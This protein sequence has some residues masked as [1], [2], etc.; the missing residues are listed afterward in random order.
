MD[1]AHL[2]AAPDFVLLARRNN[3][4]SRASRHRVFGSLVIVSLVI[5]LGFA[6]HGACLVLPFAGAEVLVLYLAFRAVERHAGDFEI[7]S[8]RG[9]RLVLERWESG[10]VSR[11]EFSRYWAQVVFEPSGAD[12]HAL[13][14]VRS[15]GRQVRFGRHLTD[16]QRREAARTLKQQLNGT[17]H[18]NQAL[19]SGES[20]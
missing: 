6:L 20:K 1:S 15:H 14:A 13:L 3:S 17:R 11:A 7:V 2:G 4:L 19:E 16:E 18:W 9:D 10:R 5:S 12:G 8:I